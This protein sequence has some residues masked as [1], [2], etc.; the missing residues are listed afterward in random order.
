MTTVTS[1][2][3]AI[4]SQDAARRMPRWALLLLCLA[5]ILP[6]FVGRQPWKSADIAA[7]G[8]M[9]EL[10]NNAAAAN[11]LSPTLLGLPDDSGALLPYWLGAWALQLLTPLIDPAWAARVPFA[12]LLL[13]ALT[14][15]WYAI[16]ELARSPN[17]QPVAFAFGGEADPVSYAR[18]VADGGILALIAC[19]GL[20]QLSHETTPAL[21]Q[22]AF[23]A[24]TL[25][26]AARMLRTPLRGLV[27][28]AIGINGLVLSGAAAAGLVL[29]V[30]SAIIIIRELAQTP[31]S[32]PDARSTRG[33]PPPPVGGMALIAALVAI[34]MGSWGLSYT[35]NLPV[36]SSGSWPSGLDGWRIPGVMTHLLAWFAWPAWP[37]AAWTLWRWRGQWRSAHIALPLSYCLVWLAMSA[38]QGGSDRG[39]MP[40]LPAIATLAA[41][42]LPTL[43]RGLSAFIDWF[44]LLFFTGCAVVI[45]VVWLSLQTGIPTQPAINVARLAPGFTHVFSPWILLLA[46]LATV[47]WL[48]LLAWRLGRH[49][50]AVWKSMV[51]PAGGAVLCWGL[52]MTL[53]LPLLDFA[54]SYASLVERVTRIMVVEPGCADVLGLNRAQL[55]A[56]RFHGNLTL[57]PAQLRTTAFPTCPWLIVDAD[58]R[59]SLAGLDTSQWAWVATVRRPSD[60]DEDVL[61]FRRRPPL[62]SL[63]ETAHTPDPAEPARRTG[64]GADAGAQPAA[65]NTHAPSS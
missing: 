1:T 37:L 63:P 45:W 35:L 52:L 17:A 21:T 24:L 32:A 31:R 8:L 57:L 18:A 62:L 65:V 39:L 38:G 33:A 61:L 60:K 20:A 54:R 28:L 41:F 55:A 48:G 16:Y 10:A 12:L 46:V 2:T 14:A 26:G 50:S 43:K 44:A 34:V 56:F 22:L 13:T 42:A 51:L 5:Y 19:L 11:W 25:L 7:F 15:T 3:P 53:W 6:G 59:F 64:A 58:A 49:R 30:G 27:L 4:V 9:Q 23:S 40:G 36:I 47:G 29:G